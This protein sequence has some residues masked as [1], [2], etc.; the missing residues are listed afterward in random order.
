MAGLGV[1]EFA[2]LPNA[3]GPTAR[4]DRAASLWRSTRPRRST[5]EDHSGDRFGTDILP[6]HFQHG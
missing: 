2:A 5:L 1:C 4:A 3:C 6:I